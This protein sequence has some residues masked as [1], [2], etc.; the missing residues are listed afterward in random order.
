MT[1]DYK[2]IKIDNNSNI[3]ITTICHNIP[4]IF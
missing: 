1:P 4:Y 2:L 3:N